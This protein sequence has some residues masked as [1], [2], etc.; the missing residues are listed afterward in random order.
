MYLDMVIYNTRGIP[1]SLCDHLHIAHSL[2]HIET[3]HKY[4]IILIKINQRKK[5]TKKEKNE[6]RKKREKE[7][8]HNIYNFTNYM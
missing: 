6:G 5:E 1:M 3:L 8:K 4:I 7:R 2:I